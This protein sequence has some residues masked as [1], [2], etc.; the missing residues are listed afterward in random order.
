MSVWYCRMIFI[1]TSHL[2]R[3]ERWCRAVVCTAWRLNLHIIVL[4]QYYC[5]IFLLLIQFFFL[6]TFFYF[7]FHLNNPWQPTRSRGRLSQH[8]TRAE[9]FF[10]KPNAAMASN[11]R[12]KYSQWNILRDTLMIERE[13]AVNTVSSK[14]KNHKMWQPVPVSPI[15]YVYT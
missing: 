5:L 10:D 8:F 6:H 11:L 14:I 12:G 7:F 9:L 4:Y 2:T 13:T 3:P 1:S 15:I